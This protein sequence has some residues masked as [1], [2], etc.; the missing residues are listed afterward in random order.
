M[1]IDRR[2]TRHRRYRAV[3]LLALT[4]LLAGI[5]PPG[6]LAAHPVFADG[7]PALSFSTTALDFGEQ[8]V[9]TSS[10]TR[11][12][13]LTNTGAAPL[14][15]ISIFISGGDSGSFS[16]ADTC[17]YQAL[18]PGNNCTVQVGFAPTAPGNHASTLVLQDNALNSAQSLSLTGIGIG[19]GPL[20]SLNANNLSFGDQAVGTTSPTRTITL[21]NTGAIALA[22]SHIS[23]SAMDPIADF[24]EADTCTAA[25]I[26]SGNTCSIDIGF[27]P[28]RTGNRTA[29]LSIY[30]NASTSP[31]LVA[32]SGNGTVPTPIVSLSTDILDFGSQDLGTSSVFRPVTLTNTGSAPL[33]ID[34]I[35][36][37][38]RDD[39]LADFQ[40]SNTCVGHLIQPQGTCAINL[41][42][43]PTMTS[44]RA[45]AVA[46]DDN[47]AGS[48]HTL[49]VSGLGTGH[50]PTLTINPSSLS[51]GYQEANTASADQIVTITNTSPVTQA[52][53]G[54][55]LLSDYSFGTGFST[56]DYT[57][58]GPGQSCVMGFSFAPGKPGSYAAYLSVSSSSHG[59]AYVVMSGVGRITGP[60]LRSSGP[61][62]LT[63]F[64]QNAGTVGATQTLTFTNT[65]A[66]LIQSPSVTLGGDA[67]G[68]SDFR[69]ADDCTASSSLL[70]GQSC[71]IQVGFASQ[72]AGYRA[73]TLTIG[74]NPN[75]GLAQSLAL[76]GVGVGGPQLSITSDVIEFGPQPVGTTGVTKTLTLTNTGIASLE[77]H[78]ISLST[79][80]S[81]FN[82]SDTCRSRTLAPTDSCT[83]SVSFRPV[84]PGSTADTLYISALP[85][86]PPT[87]V[88]ALG[89]TGIIAND[90]VPVADLSADSISFGDDV[91]G[92]TSATRTI[93]LTNSGAAPLVVGDIFP[94][95]F[96]FGTSDTCRDGPVA[97]GQSCTI[98]VSFTPFTA[99]SGAAL[100][101]IDDNTANSPH[102]VALS[103]NGVD[104][105]RSPGLILSATGLDFGSQNTGTTSATQT[106]T[107]TN[108]LSSTMYFSI[109]DAPV[110]G[111][112][113]V[114][115]GNCVDANG[116]GN[117]L[118]G[119]SCAVSASFVPTRTGS[120]ATT[121]GVLSSVFYQTVGLSGVGIGGDPQLTL[122]KDVVDFGKQNIGTQSHDRTITL[123]DTG[124]SQVVVNSIALN[125]HLYPFNDYSETDTCI[126]IILNPGDTCTVHVGFTPVASG[127]R[128]TTLTIND[129]AD[130]TGQSVAIVGKGIGSDPAFSVSSGSLSFGPQ[131]AGTTSATQTITIT[132]SS[133]MSLGVGIEGI[134]AGYDIFSQSNTCS[135]ALEPGA[136]CFINVSF[137]PQ[138]PGSA[139]GVL[140]IFN[141][142]DGQTQSIAL[143]GIGTPGGPLPILSPASLEFGSQQLGTTG[144]VQAITLTNT[145]TAPLTLGTV[146]LAYPNK[147]FSQTNDCDLK[148]IVPGGT[149]TIDV[150]F[151][152]TVAG[153]EFSTL[154]VGYGIIEAVVK[155]N[156]VSPGFTAGSVTISGPRNLTFGGQAVGT[157]SLTQTITLANTGAQTVTLE[158]VGIVGEANF[159]DGFD[160]FVTDS[161]GYRSPGIAPGDTCSVGV[162]FTPSRGGH[163]NALLGITADDTNSPQYI[164]LNGLGVGDDPA[165]VA[166]QGSIDF[167]SQT[168]GTT[169][170]T[171]T[172]TLT[173]LGPEA[174]SLNRVGIDGDGFAIDASRDA[175]SLHTIT[176]GSSCTVGVVF[177]PA[178]P[179]P[180]AAALTFGDSFGSAS[181]ALSGVGTGTPLTGSLSANGLDFGSQTV[182]TTSATQTITFTNTSAVAVRA[183]PSIDEGY[184]T[185]YRVADS[186]A[187]QAIPPGSSCTIE[188]ALS[189]MMSGSRAQVLNVSL[190]I[191][192]PYGPLATL[193]VAVSGVGIGSDP[194]PLL[195]ASPAT[196]TFGDQ[197]I[198]SISAEQLISVRANY[199]AA[200]KPEAYIT[201][202][203]AAAFQLLNDCPL[204][205]QIQTC[206]IGVNYMPTTLGTQEA[207][208][209][210]SNG[211]FSPNQAVLVMGNGVIPAPT[212]TPTL[213][214]NTP[215]TIPP[216]MPIPPATLPP[217]TAT[218]AGST[219]G[220]TPGQGS[221]QLTP[222][223][224]PV[225]AATGMA[226]PSPT[227]SA[228]TQTPNRTATP[229]GK[230]PPTQTLN[231]TGPHSLLP[232]NGTVTVRLHT[233]RNAVVTLSLRLIRVTTVTLGK[234]RHRRRVSRSQLLYQ[235]TLHLKAD[236]HGNLTKRVQMR[237]AP[238]KPA[239]VTLVVSART[240]HSTV[241][242]TI[243]IT[244]LPPPHRSD[245]KIVK[246]YVLAATPP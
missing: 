13:T 205:I 29:I 162:A 6:R 147:D 244:V 208:V 119:Q 14:I 183:V 86:G 66:Q 105:T 113:Q 19:V 59:S 103:G 85:Y 95:L 76:S 30:D 129:S 136:T 207:T 203:N 234:G 229:A 211:P 20:V 204:F 191:D 146:S 143:N 172:I 213:S 63:Y 98:Q 9:G 167:G 111:A 218:S 189:P 130:A 99:G 33:L 171:Q 40:E 8:A 149:C 150:S 79:L 100:L 17:L 188:V 31:H 157:A 116:N 178:H 164:A 200:L 96:T 235:V 93:T 231:V 115:T 185:D 187:N 246:I 176:P 201:G 48:P 77:I 237:Y 91:V 199:P 154:N 123:T 181:V 54:P 243:K 217:A 53:K 21:S 82:E 139:A 36:L 212:N 73:D 10:V 141:G 12:I 220:G 222:T 44:S 145:G 214:P 224:T 38:T 118:A 23:I 39:G 135:Q 104:P 26:A 241:T 156:G 132:N 158:G 68:T 81:S 126:G 239:Q 110:S 42:F 28:L 240:L 177:A 170:A 210:F 180:V 112:F 194:T 179:G 219:G 74:S 223:R 152:P 232:A 193:T 60:I 160:C 16:E 89:G 58:L 140:T 49:V 151:S 173:N 226:L 128:F 27:T 43:A 32:L 109:R 22:I 182:N 144:G 84:A 228:Q 101:G 62:L 238:Q 175:C 47:A 124:P 198:G 206:T 2:R 196:L 83:V 202:P 24:S 80:R 117:L 230:R 125:Q 97:P 209:V 121:L 107:L 92:T 163:L 37:S 56:C 34:S 122:N 5:A 52:L 168:L 165:I 142:G 15:F 131:E 67:I 133:A 102:Y 137:R 148:S 216:T 184:L 114:T 51:F 45:A 1:T 169:S 64:G 134:T 236:Q 69:E 55:G 65:G 195:T 72:G 70:P 71:A 127:I 197:A 46:I 153:P 78:D 7:S 174:R 108:A 225:P 233:D 161:W 41:I 245:E 25:P 50:S 227:R 159:R 106:L 61:T 88:V 4:C 192:W 155:G 215:T 11:T 138:Q 242:R 94:S 166:S 18:A 190:Y 120:Q 3:L 57:D 221:P 75:G 186:C 87:Y 90:V 35:G